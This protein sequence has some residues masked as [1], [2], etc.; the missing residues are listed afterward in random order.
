[1]LL[2]HIPTVDNRYTAI[3]HGRIDG[4]RRRGRQRRRL[5]DGF[6]EWNALNI[7]ECIQIV[8]D[9]SKRS[10]VVSSSLSVDPQN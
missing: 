4:I 10:A 3:L 6:K 1:M 9:R 7:Q 8:A 5:I 2:D